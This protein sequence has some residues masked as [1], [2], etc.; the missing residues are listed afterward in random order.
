MKKIVNVLVVLSIITVLLLGVKN[1]FFPSDT[2]E[3]YGIEL[4]GVLTHNTFRG[5]ISG[6]LIGIGL[7]LLMGLLTKN[8]T[9]YQSS[10]LL[11]SVILFGRTYSVIVDGWT[12][13]LMPPMV[14]EVFI[15]VVLYFASKQLD[16]S[17]KQ[18]EF[19]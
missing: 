15:I 3:L 16:V 11:I 7:T 18:I 12:N 14:V 5:A 1:M 9:W 19:T 2:F 4:T 17:K 13:A 10:L 8:K 6:T